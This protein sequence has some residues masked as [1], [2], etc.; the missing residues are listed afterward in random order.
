MLVHPRI[1]DKHP[2]ITDADVNWAWNNYVSA[3]VRDAR[4]RE[5]RIGFDLK[6]RAIEMVG[7]FMD[8]DWLVFHAMT[9]PSRKTYEEIDRA[10]RGA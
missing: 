4:E 6:G 7:V 10:K 9:P 5:M 1:H 2:E 8:D 3:A